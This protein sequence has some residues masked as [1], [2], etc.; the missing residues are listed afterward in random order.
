[1]AAGASLCFWQGKIGTPLAILLR[2]AGY[3]LET[4]YA[5]M[6]F[7]LDCTVPALGP[8]SSP[9]GNMLPWQSF[10]TD[11]HTPVELSWEWG[12]T[13]ED[14]SI[15]YALEPIGFSA[16]GCLDPLNP[17]ASR[18]LIK[19]L[20][21]TVLNLNLRW[22]NHYAEQL[23]PNNHAPKSQHTAL[24]GKSPVETPSS[25][26]IAY[27]LRRKGP[28]IV[29]AYFLPSIRATQSKVSNFDLIVQA[30]RSLP[31]ASS[32]SFQAL[33]LLTEFTQKDPL[34][35]ALE[36]DILGIDCVPEEYARLK[37][38]LRSR[39][40]SFDSALFFPGKQQVTNTG[41]DLQP[42]AHRTA[43]VLYYF[44]FSKT[45][46]KPAPK[47]YLPV[48]HYGKSDYLIATA[49]CTYMKRRDKQQEACQY[50]SALE[51]IFT[52]R[53][54]ENSLGAQTYIAC[55]IKG[56]QLM[57]TSYINPKVYSKPTTG[58]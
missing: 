42:C 52:T 53:E 50:L 47:V 56:G 1:M 20:Q 26:F 21:H 29:K 49:L 22:Y 17:Q 55:A 5:H 4:Q 34:G 19:V 18:N 9:L 33:E 48:R 46:P 44:D 27:D 37:I 6:R 12:H 32:G 43:G 23:E 11:D 16:G 51:E 28:M 13:G 36:C 58:T 14:V 57:I 38:Y 2:K 41:G 40:T 45:K 30:I 8:A 25:S 31:E 24:L 54:L 35:P 7:F 39:C 15:R 10:M 3:N